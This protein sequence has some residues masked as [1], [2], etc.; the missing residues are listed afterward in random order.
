MPDLKV[1]TK[2]KSKDLIRL[3]DDIKKLE[4]YV[5]IPENKSSRKGEEITNAELCYI[6]TNGSPINHIPARPIIEPAIEAED[7]KEAITEELK[8]AAKAVLEGKVDSAMSHLN[9][10]GM[11]GQN[12]ARGWFT[13]SRNNWAENS[14]TTARN[15]LSKLQGKELKN[16]QKLL[17]AGASIT[18]KSVSKPLIDTGELRKSIIYVV[19]DA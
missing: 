12:A 10:A 6:H 19:K 7:N 11:L 4:V 8:E 16:L 17:D 1:K 5:G 18:D 15:K 9:L 14:E 3:L 2:D 13:D